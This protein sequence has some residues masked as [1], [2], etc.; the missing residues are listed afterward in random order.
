MRCFLS[1]DACS[2]T[3][4]PSDQRS[5]DTVI[6]ITAGRLAGWLAAESGRLY[7]CWSLISVLSQSVVRRSLAL[8]TLTSVMFALAF[9]VVQRWLGARE[10]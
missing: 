5:V 9:V 8:L 6:D 7:D 4:A 10:D 1:I 2:E 3:E